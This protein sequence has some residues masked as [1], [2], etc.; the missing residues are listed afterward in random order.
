MGLARVLFGVY[1]EQGLSEPEGIW[2]A[3]EQSVCV[4]TRRCIKRT[5]KEICLGVKV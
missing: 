5:K 2:C 4:D 3:G 1:L